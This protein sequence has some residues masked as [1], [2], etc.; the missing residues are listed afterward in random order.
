MAL[1]AALLLASLLS[2]AHSTTTTATT[3][4]PSPTP[5]TYTL[6]TPSPS[7]SPIPVTSQGQLI[8]S[9]VPQYA[10]CNPDRS[11]CTTVYS[12][13]TYAWCSTTLPCY[14]HSCTVTDC[15]QPI[16]FSHAAS[17]YLAS[18]IC[19][20][21]GTHTVFG[22]PTHITAAPTTLYYVEPVTTRYVLPY[23]DYVE[24]RYD[25]VV[26]ERCTEVDPAQTVCEVSTERWIER[27]SLVEEIDVLPVTLHTYCEK[28]TTVTWA[29]GE[30]VVV[31][32]PS[33]VTWVT[34]STRTSTL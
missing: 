23:T 18:T 8:T 14:P 2:T 10:I 33:T 28:A 26:V 32:R 15:T 34:G 17:Y 30:S 31:E 20:T 24:S 22:T 11:D 7:A 16:T 25:E 12:P 6:I 21:S 9:H 4:C 3:A 13:T 29:A 19:T 5:T 1:R 27:I